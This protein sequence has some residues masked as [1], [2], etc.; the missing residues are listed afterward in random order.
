MKTTHA[1]ADWNRAME[2]ID[3]IYLAY[4]SPSPPRDA[5]PGTRPP[6]PPVPRPQPGI[7]PP[8][9]PGFV[10]TG[11]DSLDLCLIQR[12]QLLVSGAPDNGSRPVGVSTYFPP[13]TD[14][15]IPPLLALPHTPG[16]VLTG[17]PLVDEM[18]FLYWAERH[19]DEESLLEARET[20]FDRQLVRHKREKMFRE[21]SAEAEQK[22]ATAS[23]A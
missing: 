17:D 6:R 5:P 13:F 14:A 4:G 22:R 21:R 11:D 19:G 12:Y 9:P 1:K 10:R 2:D 7:Q 18:L 8:I 15:D 23:T 20:V 3:F 16:L